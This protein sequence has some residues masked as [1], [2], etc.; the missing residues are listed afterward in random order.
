LA[1]YQSTG[2]ALFDE[3]FLNKH[4][5]GAWK[6]GDAD[7]R[8]ADLLHIQITSRAASQPLLDLEGYENVVLT[9]LYQL[10]GS[11]RDAGE[12]HF[13][14]THFNP[15]VWHVINSSIRP[16]TLKW[17]RLSEGGALATSHK[18]EFRAEFTALQ[19]VLTQLDDLL[20]DIRD[21]RAS[22]P[23]KSAP[24]DDSSS[25][26]E[27]TLSEKT[28]IDALIMKGGGVKGLAFAGA[29]RELERFFDFRAFVGTSAGA[30][31]AALLGAGA[32]GAQL[33]D[34]LSRKPFREFLDGNLWITPFTFWTLRGLHPGYSFV[35]W[36]REELHACISN[37]Y[38][39]ILMED[40][41]K[42]AVVYASTRDAGEIIFDTIGEHK[43]TAV[44]TAVRCSMSIPYFFQP[45]W[46]NNRR[47]YDGGLLH[48][49]PVQVFLDQERQ[50]SAD[51]P[52]PNFI[53]LY[54]GSSKPRPLNPGF[55][56]A[57]LLSISIDR[58]DAKLIN[59][60]RA[61]TILIETDPIG[62][63]DF[64]LTDDDKS[65]L[66]HQGQVAALMFL[67]DRGVLDGSE[68]QSLDQLRAET[69]VLRASVN[70]ARQ[71]ARVR[72]R[73]RLLPTV[74]VLSL[75]CAGGFAL[76][77]FHPETITGPPRAC[78]LTATVEM[79]VTTGEVKPLFLALSAGGQ[80]TRYPIELPKSVN[81]TILPEHVSS[82]NLALE[83]SDNTRSNFG[84]LSGCRSEINRKSDDG[85]S[86][87]HLAVHQ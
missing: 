77:R 42:R 29:I 74:V 28:A 44:H 87:L 85:R 3:N 43:D 9:S 31:A 48:N 67:A 84:D 32:T 73:R 2:P 49:Y 58:N 22:V 14:A 64:D 10:F 65:Y 80:M 62:T 52:Q 15:L 60:Y 51:K 66:V 35:N 25:R 8:A 1:T 27:Q 19:R 69:E 53:A 46:F 59:Q 81:L 75:I 33:E 37:K 23:A 72:F 79:P 36:I 24:S 34:K 61:Q 16:F 26:A 45:Q 4:G 76:F 86:T 20:L 17:H 13:G 47:V 12:K 41:P 82:Y 57:D 83:W 30:I 55:V 56:F 63:I 39:D 70:G 11:A 21:G 5:N 40:L 50:R 78:Q 38:G 7:K 54:L 6:P 18:E 68:M 71:K